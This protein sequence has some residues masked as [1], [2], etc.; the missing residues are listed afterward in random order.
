MGKTIR[1][2]TCEL[3]RFPD[4]SS[5]RPN[6]IIKI[7]RLK[8]STL[9]S[10]D[11]LQYLSPR[12]PISSASRSRRRLF[13]SDE[14]VVDLPSLVVESRLPLVVACWFE[15]GTAARRQISSSTLVLISSLVVG[16]GS[17]VSSPFPL[18]PIPAILPFPLSFPLSHLYF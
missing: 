1:K 18:L 11:S 10:L 13:S 12:Q 8:G 5:L 6:L 16:S 7:S 3:G 17:P 9:N 15:L 2:W 14:L 4:G